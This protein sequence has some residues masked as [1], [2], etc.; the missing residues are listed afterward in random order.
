[1]ESQVE[2]GDIIPMREHS[3]LCNHEDRQG[4]VNGTMDIRGSG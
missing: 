2:K 3:Q 4:A 1:M